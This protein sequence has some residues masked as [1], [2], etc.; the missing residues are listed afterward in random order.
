MTAIGYYEDQDGLP[1]NEPLQKI[2]LEYRG[3]SDPSLSTSAILSPQNSQAD[4]G[5]PV[6]FGSVHQHLRLHLGPGCSRAGP[7]TGETANMADKADK[8]DEPPPVVE[9]PAARA[10]PHS[11]IQTDE[12]GLENSV[13]PAIDSNAHDRITGD[14]SPET[15]TSEL[16]ERP[17]QD[18]TQAGV[19]MAW[20]ASRSTHVGLKSPLRI[21][22]ES[23]DPEA[24]H[25]CRERDSISASPTLSKH[26][27]PAADARGQSLAPFE[28]L[29]PSASPPKAERLPSIHQITSSLTELAEAATQEI[30]RHQQGFSHHHS[31]SFGSAM[32]Q[33]P[34][35]PAHAYPASI[36]TSPQAY[37]PASMMA[38]SPTSTMG[39]SQ[40]ASPPAYPRYGV[41]G[42]R[43][44]SMVDGVPPIVPKLPTA[45]SSGDSYSGYLSSGTEGYSTNHT[46]PIDIGRSTEHT[47][48]PMLPPPMG[49]QAM[50][51]PPTPIMVPGP[52]R[53]DVPNCQAGTFQTQYLL[54]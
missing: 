1:K 53:C 9:T 12:R 19:A 25:A 26:V 24:P 38:P 40:Y 21:R 16:V 44:V 29:S 8:A 42:A 43:R 5:L 14:S 49:M 3:S 54:K 7:H 41:F 15:T 33:S 30:P 23:F 50:S 17:R 48:R 39:E 46:T 32:S 6:L 37:Y 28:P 10:A 13:D 4:P 35:P 52:Y 18:S 47:P 2:I 34:I 51:I 22:T 36:Q 20:K 27:L 11:D 31:Q 45:S